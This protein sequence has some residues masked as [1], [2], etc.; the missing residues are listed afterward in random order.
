ML[1]NLAIVKVTKEWF[2][3]EEQERLGVSKEF[4]MLRKEA[5]AAIRDFRNL[6]LIARFRWDILWFSVGNDERKWA[7]K[8][9]EMINSI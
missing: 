9:E 7:N 3:W 4:F 5:S 2:N 1:W 8:E 6:Q